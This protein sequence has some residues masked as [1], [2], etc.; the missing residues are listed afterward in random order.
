MQRYIDMLEIAS[1][2][3]WHTTSHHEASTWIH[4]DP[5]CNPEGGGAPP[6][7]LWGPKGPKRAR[8]APPE[9][10]GHP[11]RHGE[12]TRGTGDNFGKPTFWHLPTPG[13]DSWPPG[14]KS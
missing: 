8:G 14:L 4:V 7:A 11:Q 9:A 5:T 3:L 13:L 1:R 12:P 6:W 2:P 10:R